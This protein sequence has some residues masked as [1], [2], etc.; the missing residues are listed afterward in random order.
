MGF[1]AWRIN[2]LGR[3]GELAMPNEYRL[4]HLKG[5]PC[6]K[7]DSHPAVRSAM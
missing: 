2:Q 5:K 3:D 6:R 1:I 7:G 4:G